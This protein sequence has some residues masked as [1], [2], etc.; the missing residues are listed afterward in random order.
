MPPA[1]CLGHGGE[2]FA[3]AFDTAEAGVQHQRR[4]GFH[5]RAVATQAAGV[6]RVQQHR[7]AALLHRA[8]VHGLVV[9]VD[10]LGRRA[11]GLGRVERQ[12][13]QACSHGSSFN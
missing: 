7:V 2:R 6:Q 1:R 3:P 10:D 8:P 12:V 11:A 13:L 5:R 9:A 4:S